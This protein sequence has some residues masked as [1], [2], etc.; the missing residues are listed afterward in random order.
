[1]EENR[2]YE[3][4]Y[5][6]GASVPKVFQDADRIMEQ[7]MKPI[8]IVTEPREIPMPRIEGCPGAI[9][10]VHITEEWYVDKK[11]QKQIKRAKEKK[12]CEVEMIQ[13]LARRDMIRHKLGEL[14]PGKKKDYKKIAA[15]N[16]S[17]K[18]ISAEL[19][20]LEEQS[21]IH[22]DELDQG[23]RIGKFIGKLKHTAKKVV[24]SVKKFYHKNMELINGLAAIIL[25][26]VG[27]FLFKAIFRI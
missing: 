18:D 10:P 17:L 4:F 19:R 11:R 6:P 2:M 21:G 14:D 8:R 15:M 3:Q 23:T 24:K 26:V 12:D 25:P 16:I 22:L 27:A 5:I 7:Q 9:G 13:L 20:M 1:M